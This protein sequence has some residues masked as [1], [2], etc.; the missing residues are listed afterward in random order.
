MPS[1]NPSPRIPSP[2]EVDGIRIDSLV[3]VLCELGRVERLT[4]LGTNG[5]L[6]ASAGASSLF[7][8]LFGRDSIRM[9]MDLLDD[10]PAVG[11]ETLLELAR[12]QGVTHNPRGEEEPGRIL[13]EFRAPDDPLA[14]PLFSIGWDFPFYGSVDATPQWINLLGAYCAAHGTDLLDE[15]LTDRASPSRPAQHRQSGL[16]RLVGFLL[17]RRRQHLRFHAPVRAGGRPGVRL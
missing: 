10:F 15:P 9:A 8:C 3:S 6:L 7:H 1:L 2:V 12:L 13:H 16:G 4:D 11:R 17:P 5:P 14:A